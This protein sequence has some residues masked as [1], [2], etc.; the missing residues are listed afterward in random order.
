MGIRGHP[1]NRLGLAA[2]ASKPSGNQQDTPQS[3]NDLHKLLVCGQ[4]G[5]GWASEAWNGRG[6]GSG[7]C[8]L[9]NVR[10]QEWEPG[11]QREGGPEAQARTGRSC[12]MRLKGWKWSS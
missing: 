7:T 5:P 3:P 10:T 8:S 12:G 9:S 4:A 2:Q 1:F 11:A 6:L